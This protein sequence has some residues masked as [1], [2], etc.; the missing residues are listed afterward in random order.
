MLSSVWK[1]LRFRP[2]RSVIALV[3]ALVG[4]LV[5]TLA[6]ALAFAQGRAANTSSDLTQ[7]TAGTHTKNNSTI[8]NL[9]TLAD[10]PKLQKLAPDVLRIDAV[11]DEYIDI[12][13]VGQTRYK[14]AGSRSTGPYY[15]ELT[16]LKVLHGSY[17]NAKDVQS[18][19]RVVLL[20]ANTALALFGREDAVGETISFGS[21]AYGPGTAR[22][23]PYRVI[24]I[25]EAAKPGQSGIASPLI[26]PL[27]LGGGIQASSV[28]MLARPGRLKEA[29]EQLLRAALQVYK[30]NSQLTSSISKDQRGFFFTSPGDPFGQANMNTNTP[31]LR[32]Y[33]TIAALTLIVSSLGVLSALLVSVNERTHELGLRRAI[34]ATWGQIGASLLLETGLTTLLGSLIGTGLALLLSP[35]LA[36]LFSTLLN[37]VTLEITPALAVTVIGL[38]VGLSLLFGL[39]PAIV[40]TRMRPT[41]AL[42]VQG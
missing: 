19:A 16:G 3:Q 24:G 14:L 36:G 30:S 21:N 39:V 37:G 18:Q 12:L 26:K 33:Y 29:K 34:G 13:S 35:T 27:T 15:P 28:L 23:A 17:F 25:T 40:S 5:V 1:S 31:M 9:F 20:S 2:T 7:M 41:E 4:A 42:R 22:P 11:G 38:F 6:L 10:L 32:A 8:F